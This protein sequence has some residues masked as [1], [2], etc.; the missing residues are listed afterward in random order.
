MFRGGMLQGG[1]LRGRCRR[2]MLG[3]ASGA[4]LR[5]E[6]FSAVV[7]RANRR[8]RAPCQGASLNASP[9]RERAAGPKSKSASLPEGGEA[10]F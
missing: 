7:V 6:L 1:I 8:L 9:G 10:D 3:A 4:L 2:E 5:R